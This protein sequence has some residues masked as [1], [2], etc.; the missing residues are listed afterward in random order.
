MRTYSFSG[1]PKHNNSLSRVAIF[2]FQ[3]DNPVSLNHTPAAYLCNGT[4]Y[5]GRAWP[6]VPPFNR[7]NETQMLRTEGI[8]TVRFLVMKR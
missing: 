7:R 3:S 5:W 6:Q 8:G 4:M 2:I 1:L